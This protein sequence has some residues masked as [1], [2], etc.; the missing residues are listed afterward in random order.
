MDIHEIKEF[1]YKYKVTYYEEMQ[2]G[3]HQLLT[4]TGLTFG[5][6]FNEACAKIIDYFG[7][8]QIEHLEVDAVSDC[9]VIESD[10]LKELFSDV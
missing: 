8:E 4:T 2:D 9:D 10:E 5:E 6:T 3:K 7:E 1:F